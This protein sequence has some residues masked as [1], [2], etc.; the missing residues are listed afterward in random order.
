M[1][2]W[3]RH[4]VSPAFLYAQNAVPSHNWTPAHLVWLAALLA[5]ACVGLRWAR[6]CHAAGSS[7]VGPGA[8]VAALL[9]AALLLVA[10]FYTS[11]ILS[12]RIWALSASGLAFG[13]TLMRTVAT[14]RLPPLWEPIVRALAC[15]L[16]PEGASLPPRLTP[17]W[18][19]GQ[20]LGFALLS[21]VDG[22]LWPLAPWA[23][24]LCALACLAAASWRG[25]RSGRRWRWEIWAPLALAYAGSGLRLIVGRGV[26]VDTAAYAAFPYPDPW[27]PW[28]DPG[29]TTLAACAWM[30]AS[31]AVLARRAVNSPHSHS[32]QHLTGE[33]CRVRRGQGDLDRAQPESLRLPAYVVLGLA[34]VW[35]GAVVVRHLSH[36]ASGS[37]PFCYLQMATDL[38][39]HGT[40]Q[41]A[42][43]LARLA[44][45]AGL[46]VWPVT[47]VGYHPPAV[48]LAPTVWPAGWPVLLA[49]L[50]ALGGERLAL[51][52]AP[53]WMVVAAIL[54]YRLT[55]DLAPR[56]GQMGAALAG[57]LVLTS[58]E[59]VLRSLVPMADAAATAL[60]L[61][62]LLC[63]WR[64]RQ[65]NALAWS[66]L[67]G[68]CWG[69][70]Y[71]V[72]HPN[73]GL[74]LAA[75]PALW[76]NRWPWRRRIGHALAFGGLALL[77]ASPDLAYHARVMGAPWISESPEWFLL[78]W[79]HIGPTMRAMVEDGWLRRNEWGYLLPLIAYGAWRQ[80]RG[81]DERPAAW[82]LWT[83]LVPV[84]GFHLCYSALRLRDLL[85]LFPWAALWT[86]RG[87]VALWE[88]AT[89]APWRLWERAAVACA[90]TLALMARSFHTLGLPW[91]EQVQTFGHVSAT[92][93]AAYAS[94]STLLPAN[95][96][97]ATGLNS[98][99]VARYTAA[100]TFRP[101][102]WTTD[103]FA[104]FARALEEASYTLYILDDGEEMAI[105]CARQPECA[106][107]QPLGEF[108]IPTFGLGGQALERAAVLFAL[109]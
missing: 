7:T 107:A 93:R 61:G 3:L 59:G 9:V 84:L 12:A 85:P 74:G 41:H 44:R 62:L 35:Y 28:F 72:R 95:A 67:A 56:S 104:R 6:R 70:V 23:L 15:D 101:A 31:A 83:G 105:W 1:I 26:G 24:A 5:L 16:H 86:V 37:D 48:E 81:R 65:R 34:L 64:S 30:L 42:F 49:P 79:R 98:G 8:V 57:V 63:L 46:A 47:P 60:S 13:L 109:P 20:G 97:V 99:A 108:G 27:S 45:E 11:G 69:L 89:S 78:S 17:F 77:V 2:A 58:C 94:L 52:G 29:V 87:V 32:L 18:L 88:K 43:P 75:L 14:R 21:W 106:Q 80:G 39:T 19:L 33:E 73:L 68:L 103:E 102:S 40:P 50:Y 36:G 51:W 100:L 4:V 38:V 82:L 10:Q 76:A 96:V 25:S 53:L 90:L 54:T 22:D 55:R 92:Q 91:V 71:A 66:A